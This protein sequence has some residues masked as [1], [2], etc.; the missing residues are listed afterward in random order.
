MRI[1]LAYGKE[2]LEVRLPDSLDATVIEPRNRKAL[3]DPGA[4][5]RAALRSPIA[6]PPLLEIVRRGRRIGIV[7]SDLTRP[8]PRPLLLGALLDEIRDIPGTEV[9]LFNALGTHRPSPAAELEEMLG[10][11]IARRNRIVQNNAY[12]PGTQADLGR[13]SFGHPLRV[14]AELAACEVI[15]LSGFIEPHLFA[16]F[17]GGPKAIMPGM[18]GQ[19]TVLGNH[20]ARMIAHPGATWGATEGNPIWEEAREVVRKLESRDGG[21]S[22]FLLNIAMNNDKQVTG[23]FAGAWEEAHRRGCAFVRETAIVPVGRLFDIVVTTNSG[24]PLD[25]N[26]YQA[27]KGMS[28]AARIVRDGGAIVCAS[29]CREGVPAGSPFESLLASHRNPE[30]A[31][32][33]IVSAAE[34]LQDQWQAQIQTQIQRRAEIHLLAA[35]LKDEEIRRIHLLPCRDVASTVTELA[36]RLGPAARIAILPQ[37]P[38]TVPELRSTATPDGEVGTGGKN[39]EPGPCIRGKP[40]AA[41]RDPFPQAAIGRG[42][43][44]SRGLRR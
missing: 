35:G 38:Q 29:E 18:A 27:V 1:N 2:G 15:I 4:A 33:A 34:P 31:L 24:W 16:G 7:F 25:L 14:N 12:D 36:R 11:A 42:P 44:K 9:I 13:T 39:A 32:E 22:I 5:I 3:A 20:D 10:P 30:A 17:S 28:A 43:T 21:K 23:V 37:G 26:V 41:G 8:L 40:A 6:G 19:S